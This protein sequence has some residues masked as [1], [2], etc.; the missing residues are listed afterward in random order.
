MRYTTASFLIL[1]LSWT[2]L[3]SY[4]QKELEVFNG[5]KYIY[6]PTLMYP[7]GG[8]D[9]YGITSNARIPFIEKGFGILGDVLDP[10]SIPKEV[11]ENPCIV[12]TCQITHPSPN[13]LSNSVTL[14]FLNCK[15]QLVY[16]TK[17]SGAMGINFEG[18]YRIA[19]K[20]ALKDLSSL[21]Y[22]YN[23]TLTPEIE[24]PK[25]EISNETETSLKNYFDNNKIDLLEGIFKSYQSDMLGYYK[26]AIKKKDDKYIAIILE[27][28]NKVW[29]LG[30]I[31]ANFETSSMNGV[32]SVKWYLGDKTPYETFGVLENE[33][34]L[35]IEFKDQ[36]GQKKQDKFIKMYPVVDN[37][38]VTS[39]KR[40]SASGSGFFLS[41][42]GLIATNAHVIEGAKNIEINL[43][44]ELG[45]FTYKAKLVLIDSKNDV[46][47]IKVD[48]D[49]FKEL[50]SLPYGITE[51]AEIG[52]KA[53]TIGYPLNDIMGTNYKVTDGI[54]SAT[55]GIA[56]DVRYYQISV[57]LQPG[58]S[59]GPLFN[60][61]GNIIGITSAKLNSKAVGTTIENVNY[62][63]KSVYLSSLINILPNS[64][65]PAPSNLLINKELKDQ[66]KV[67]KNYVCIIIV[68]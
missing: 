21:K 31:K 9:I 16:K 68:N 53:F 6:F 44:N 52:E 10:N 63:I 25:V 47:I 39:K 33:S 49:K 20:K 27:T 42:N 5:Y 17:A 61:E 18:D 24:Y 12:L 11:K 40:Y 36:N 65:I 23:S 67:L 13:G 48:D 43:S 7:N 58:N 59:G 64:T 62:A 4:G 29:N 34:L 46:A 41:T 3:S 15:N 32:F 35:S 28:D 38:K 54:I 1:L 50:N 14:S 51:K 45:N 19:V 56:D 37:E 22:N 60:K 55:S 8:V 2:N 30:E 26:F 57:P 66:I